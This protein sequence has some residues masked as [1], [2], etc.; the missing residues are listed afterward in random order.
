MKVRAVAINGTVALVVGAAVV[1]YATTDNETV[2]NVCY[3]GVLVGAGVAAW[4]GAARAPQQQRLVPRLVAAGLALTAL[5]DVL[6]TVLDERGAYTDVSIADPPW[7][8]SYVVLCAAMWI[9][10][11]RSREGGRIDLGFA[12]DVVTIV[13]VSVLIF[14]SF[15]VDAIVTDQSLPPFVRAVW[16]AY[17]LLDAVLLALVIRVLVSRTARASID[18]WFAVGVCLWLAA[19]MAY[20]QSP[21]GPAQIFMDISWMVAPV[22]MARAAWRSSDVPTRRSASPALGGWGRR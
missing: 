6:W 9:I 18:V 7:F 16:A 11:K 17:P 1:G 21:D 15:S 3:L 2:A 12:I 19:D 10:L 4:I 14:W 13:I 5:G 20:L 8:A 22:L